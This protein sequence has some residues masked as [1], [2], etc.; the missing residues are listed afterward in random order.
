MGGDRL[1][2]L[3]DAG[4]PA[5][6]MLETKLLLNSV[7]SDAKRGARCMT[8]DIKDFLLASPMPKPEYMKLHIRN[9]PPDIVT[10]Y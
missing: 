7:I 2:Y 8:V 5:A 4:A 1:V 3:D 6:T 10:Q 9:F